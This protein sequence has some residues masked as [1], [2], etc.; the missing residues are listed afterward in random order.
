[1]NRQYLAETQREAAQWLGVT[2]SQ[3][4]GG[5]HDRITLHLGNESQFLVVS[6]TPSDARG[7]KNHISLVR[8]TL[9]AMGAVRIVAQPKPV[10]ASTINNPVIHKEEEMKTNNNLATI[11]D[12][13]EKLRYSEMLELASVMADA[14]VIHNL[15]RSRVNDWADLLHSVAS[16]YKE[17]GE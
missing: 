6:N 16:N 4:T 12:A 1:M 10:A 17:A 2:V 8:R 9:R 13:I 14:A 15:R 11:F 7:I 5:K 3:D